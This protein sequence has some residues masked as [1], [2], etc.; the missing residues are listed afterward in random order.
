[1]V[2]LLRGWLPLTGLS[3]QPDRMAG[4]TAIH[5]HPSRHRGSNRSRPVGACAGQRRS[6]ALRGLSRLVVVHMPTSRRLRFSS[7]RRNEGSVPPHEAAKPEPQQ[8][9]VSCCQRLVMKRSTLSLPRLI[10]SSTT[11]RRRPS[12]GGDRRHYVSTSNAILC[13]PAFL[14]SPQRA[15]NH[16]TLAKV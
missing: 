6:P 12:H 14:P 5:Q 16:P 7:F 9:S 3:A 8:V 11:S 1:M 2:R 15:I 13:V 4:R 10:P